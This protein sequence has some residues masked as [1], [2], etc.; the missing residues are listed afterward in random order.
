MKGNVTNNHSKFLNAI[1][2]IWECSIFFVFGRR[3]SVK[4]VRRREGVLWKLWISVPTGAPNHIDGA[5]KQVQ[6]GILRSICESV[7]CEKV[8]WSERHSPQSLRLE[9]YYKVSEQFQ[10][11]KT[12]SS[13]KA[14][15][16]RKAPT[17][18]CHFGLLHTWTCGTSH[19]IS[20]TRKMESNHKHFPGL[21]NQLMSCYWKL[22]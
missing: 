20:F 18:S 8:M 2:S 7:Q 22:M 5:F 21:N 17:T 4:K 11:W 14:S 10:Y 6:I 12:N 16:W 13:P 19:A 3:E 1:H 9:K 15:W